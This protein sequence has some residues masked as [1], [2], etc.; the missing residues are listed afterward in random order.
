MAYNYLW[1]RAIHNKDKNVMFDHF[2]HFSYLIH[3]RR[4][5]DPM[6]QNIISLNTA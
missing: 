3:R 4:L 2:S 5:T 6:I 1:L